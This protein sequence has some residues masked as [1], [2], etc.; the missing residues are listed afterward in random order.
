MLTCPHHLV[1]P[2]PLYT[3]R[4][5]GQYTH[6]HSEGV[7]LTSCVHAD[8]KVEGSEQSWLSRVAKLDIC[9]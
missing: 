2:Q 8:S 5:R 7:G 3:H 6:T 4:V 9:M 1:P